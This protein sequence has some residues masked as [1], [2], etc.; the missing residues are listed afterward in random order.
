MVS[1]SRSSVTGSKK[2]TVGTYTPG[3]SGRD[4]WS[5][6]SNELLEKD[7]ERESFNGDSEKMLLVLLLEFRS[8]EL[9]VGRKAMLKP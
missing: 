9:A 5:S 2:Q 1:L 6:T 3:T 8:P 4:I 7:D